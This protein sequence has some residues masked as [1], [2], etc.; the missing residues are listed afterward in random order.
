MSHVIFITCSTKGCKSNPYP[1]VVGQEDLLSKCSQCDPKAHA[2][3]KLALREAHRIDN[4]P[5][6]QRINNTKVI[7]L[8]DSGFV[9]D[10]TP[11]VE[12]PN[13]HEKYVAPEDGIKIP[14]IPEGKPLSPQQ[15]GAATRK[16]N[17][18]KK[19]AK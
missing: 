9:L 8:K 3:V 2:A 19:V 11:G 5:K 18:T 10:D 1:V 14:V 12:V 7:S 16:L 6:S 4:S 13:T 17:A 15:R